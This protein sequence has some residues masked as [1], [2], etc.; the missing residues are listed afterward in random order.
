[1]VV[2]VLRV[3]SCSWYGE[4]HDSEQGVVRGNIMVI[5]ACYSDGMWC[6]YGAGVHGMAMVEL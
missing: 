6:G 2:M 1:M 3:G 5:R 4:I